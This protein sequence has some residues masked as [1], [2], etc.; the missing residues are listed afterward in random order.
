MFQAAGALADPKAYR[1]I[2]FEE[3]QDHLADVE[4]ILLR[5]E[6]HAP[7]QPELNAIFRAVHSIK[8]SASMLDCGDIAQMAHLQENLLD[9]LRI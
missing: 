5:L 8:G 4:A 3:T 9:L 6:P 7:C 2:F 1:A